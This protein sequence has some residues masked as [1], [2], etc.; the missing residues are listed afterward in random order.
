MMCRSLVSVLPVGDDRQLPA[1]LEMR[2]FGTLLCRPTA[3]SFAATYRLTPSDVVRLRE[4]SA[5]AP[6]MFKKI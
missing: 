5:K 2:I 3:F 6:K 1:W 4:S